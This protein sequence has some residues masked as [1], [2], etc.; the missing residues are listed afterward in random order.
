MP[1]SYSGRPSRGRNRKGCTETVELWIMLW[2]WSRKRI[3]GGSGNVS[4]SSAIAAADLE[5][6]FAWV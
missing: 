6:N 3:E 5:L 2:T 4:M 1:M